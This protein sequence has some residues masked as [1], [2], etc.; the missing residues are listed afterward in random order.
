MSPCFHKRPL[1]L[2][3]AAVS[4]AAAGASAC[5]SGT[6]SSTAAGS[7][8]TGS[9]SSA[10]STT[11]AKPEL[12]TV[13]VGALP[14][15]DAVT[16]R[17]AQKDGFFAQQ[18]LTVKIVT[19]AA[20][21]GTTPLLLA[22]TLDFTSENYVGMYFQESTTPALKL[23]VLADDGQGAAGVAELMV[24][25]GSKITSVSGLKGK[26]IALPALGVGIGPLS[27]NTTLSA[28]HLTSSDYTAVAMPFPNMAAALKS[29]AVD[30]VWATE[31]FVTILE[32]AGARP[33]ADTYTGAMNDFPISC[34]ATTGS[35]A[36]QYP[37]TTAA[38]QRAIVQAQQVAA[39]NPQLVRT[40]LP[41]YIPNLTSKIANVMTLESF[42]V[43]PSLTRMDRV[44][45]VMD[46]FKLLPSG[47]SVNSLLPAGAA[48][49]ATPSGS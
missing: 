24:P 34:W 48:A 28:Y 20:S 3:L 15:P 38:F 36:S 25:K 40:L 17:I 9:S 4:L 42:N 19:L 46:Q 39:A 37:N 22:H 29:G 41:T 26:K 12:S 30:A 23:Q 6:S 7:G 2:A 21:E 10:A 49:A 44:A 27:V 35:F 16:L 1:I 8:S 13:T 14:I 5:S 43:T 45:N 18:G 47:F 11:G 32:A 31:P 33:L